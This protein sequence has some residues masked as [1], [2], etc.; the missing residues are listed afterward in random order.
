MRAYLL[1]LLCILA[2]LPLL[3]DHTINEALPDGGRAQ[4]NFSS[5]S[6]RPDR[7]IVFALP[8]GNTIEQ[9]F[10]AERTEGVHWRYDIQHIGAQTRRLREVDPTRETALVL[11]EAK[12][13]SW[14]SW[15]KG[16]ANPGAAAHAIL[17]QLRARVPDATALTLVAH[18][19]GGSFLHAVIEG[20]GGVPPLV[21]RIAFLDANYSFDGATH[22]ERLLSWLGADAA[23]RLVI[24]AYDD[25]EVE[26]DGKKIVGP[27]GGTWRATD[28]LIAAVGDRVWWTPI[29]LPPFQA[30]TGMHGQIV[31]ARHPNPDRK[32]LHTTMVG[33]M[34]GFLWATTLG[35][36]VA[37]TWGTLAPPR[38][39]TK[40]ITAMKVPEKSGGRKP[41]K[42]APVAAIPPRPE[43]AL[44]GE[45]FI[46][47]IANLDR[48]AREEAVAKELLSGN[49]PAFLRTLT[50]VPVSGK[51][52]QGI[53]R[54]G[55][56]R[57]MP[58]YLAIG[59]NED[60]VRMPMTPQT[61]QRIADAWGMTLPTRRI[62]DAV[63][64]VANIRV[65]PRP[66]TENREAAATFLE[67]NNIIEK[68]R[69]A[70]PLGVLTT[71]MK[72]DV[73]LSN[74]LKEKP[75]RVAIYGWRKPD[76]TVIQ[77]LTIV[78]VDWYVDYSHGVRLV[79]GTMIADGKE[80]SVADV[81]A[82]PHLC[83]LVSDEGEIVPAR[84]E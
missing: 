59:S 34:N 44:G 61:A 18:S 70:N 64:A 3:A 5:E 9:T 4:W 27:T 40:W 29:E 56:I 20:P 8:N 79:A 32:I 16:Q 28:R 22:A 50:T 84:Y 78:H 49:V 1:T 24:L 2:A 53:E 80:L 68:Q 62:V 73:V 82:D 38:A 39:Y 75:N 83:V 46:E 26:L 60:F 36:P 17:T 30:T 63:D 47:S 21:E 13:L 45:A 41:P 71:G 58:D 15:R 77:S 43:G 66:M 69:A 6:A 12:G 67:H 74:R 57:V 51:D 76:G 42:P 81:L 55:E 11:I 14:P 25:R 23:R 10:G 35:T 48:T 37:T 52:I 19:G 72:K 33:E 54:T 7:V 31:I 65:E